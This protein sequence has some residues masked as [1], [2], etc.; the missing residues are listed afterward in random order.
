MREFRISMT[1]KYSKIGT[2]K[3]SREF[4]ISTAYFRE[5][6][7]YCK[8]CLQA[9]SDQY[10]SQVCCLFLYSTW[11]W[12][13]QREISSKSVQTFLSDNV[14]DLFFQEHLK[15]F[16]FDLSQ[17]ETQLADVCTKLKKITIENYHTSEYSKRVRAT[18]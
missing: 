17:H 14:Q 12:F 13:T 5:T 18:L 2:S 15:G 16:N 1:P 9:W 4:K 11:K 10:F 8:W 7:V 6:T 3:K